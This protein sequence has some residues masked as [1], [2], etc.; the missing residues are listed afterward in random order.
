M[1]VRSGVRRVRNFV[2]G[3]AIGLA[4][5][6]GCVGAAPIVVFGGISAALPGYRTVYRMR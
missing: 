6:G 3:A 1:Q 2:I 5:G 4:A